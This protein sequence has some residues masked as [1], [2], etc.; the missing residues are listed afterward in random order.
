MKCPVR[1]SHISLWGDDHF[2]WERGMAISAMT[3]RTDHTRNLPRSEY[4]NKLERAR[5]VKSI[6]WL[7]ASRTDSSL[8]CAVERRFDMLEFVSSDA[9]RA[10]YFAHR[11]SPSLTPSPYYE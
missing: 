10:K 1:S 6:S 9:F 2:A 3:N 5:L 7:L 11:T 8:F 4:R